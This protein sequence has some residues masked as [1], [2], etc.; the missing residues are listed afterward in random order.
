M[1]S[2]FISSII[3]ARVLGK[4]SIRL[5]HRFGIIDI[6]G[7][8]GHKQHER[9]PPS[10]GGI[11]LFLCLI[12]LFLLF[13]RVYSQNILVVYVSS[14]VIFIFGLTDD[15]KGL[16]APVKLI[17]QI[18]ATTV[19]VTQD[20]SVSIFYLPNTEINTMLNLVVTYF[21]VVG[22]TNA[23]NIVDGVDGLTISLG[24]CAILFLLVGSL[25][26]QQ[27]LLSIQATA[28]LV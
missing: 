17:G 5:A 2:A 21:W 26:S 18:L 13:A 24:A 8:S 25:N 20:I 7:R 11:T 23:F 22:V 10:A 14:L 3:L 28:L 12:I 15:I 27:P 19:L 4:L 6:P 16:N 9:P 1:R